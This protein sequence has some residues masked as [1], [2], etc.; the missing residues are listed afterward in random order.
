MRRSFTTEIIMEFA[1]SRSAGLIEEQPSGFK[2]SFLN[3]LDL[4]AGAFWF[5]QAN[6]LLGRV[7]TSTPRSVVKFLSPQFKHLFALFDVR[8]DYNMTRSVGCG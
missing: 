8:Q 1:F 2:S 3:A 6:P 4:A 7:M 5:G